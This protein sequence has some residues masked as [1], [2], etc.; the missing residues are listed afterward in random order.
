L[1]TGAHVAVRG[2]TEEEG[3]WREFATGGDSGKAKDT[4]RFTTMV[5]I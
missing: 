5:C 4:G 2:G 1:I 3:R